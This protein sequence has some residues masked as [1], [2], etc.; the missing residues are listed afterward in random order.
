MKDNK[1][2][3]GQCGDNRFEVIAKVKE[4]LLRST[5]IEKHPEELEVLDNILFRLWQLGYLEAPDKLAKL[6]KEQAEMKN[7][8]VACFENDEMEQ[9]ELWK[10]CGLRL[11]GWDYENNKLDENFM[12]LYGVSN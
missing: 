10:A 8:L 6:E 4:H 3:F 9:G 2:H 11:V 7:K 5:N 1:R 12:I